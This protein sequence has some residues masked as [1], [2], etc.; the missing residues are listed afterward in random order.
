MPST[1][2]IKSRPA[3]RRELSYRDPI[4]I[5]GLFAFLARRAVAGVEEVLDGVYRR[6]LRL[7]RGPAVLELA[8]GAGSVEA[9]FWLE[10][11]RDLPA[12][13]ERSRA[14]LDLDAD[15]HAVTAALGA[16][17]VLG[18]LVHRSPGRRVPGHV[19]GDELAV[20]AVLGQ[21]I[22]VAAATTLAA[23]L[24]A[25]YGE[26]LER[27][28]GSV[29]HLFP[30]SQALAGIDPVALAMPAARRR[31]VLG[32]V[33]ALSRGDVKL[34][35]CTDRARTEQALL[36]LPGIGP[37]TASYIAMRGL[38]DADA[39]LPTDL[40]VR[41]GLEALGHDG[42]PA[43]AAAIAERWRPYRAYAVQHLWAA[44]AAREAVAR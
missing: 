9:R 42:R 24:V 36:A 17:P 31:A 25:A 23:R 15:P 43:A 21:Q 1:A 37:W 5:D 19:D 13:V 4:D 40:G 20:R 27:P 22:S 11:R 3:V 34:S 33:A 14:L 26:P 7:P 41:R 16:D 18:A 12:A 44:A 2:T 28:V 32:L 29:T 35:T 8:P 6:S 10:D 30:T 38:G 39:F